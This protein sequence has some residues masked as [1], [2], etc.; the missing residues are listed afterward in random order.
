MNEAFGSAPRTSV[1]AAVPLQLSVVVPTFNERD[2]VTT[3]F[4]RLESALAGFSWEA[5]F[6]DDN[7]PDGTSEVVRLLASQD[8]RAR[9]IRRIGRRGLAGAC[10]E[11]I[12]A[13]SAPC[14]AVIDADLQHDETRLPQMLGLL[15][16][17][18]ADLVIGSRYVE[19]GSADSF[20]KQ[21]AGFSTLATEVAQRVLR[22]K[23]A[24]PMSGFFMIRRD[25]F[26]ELA[27]QLSTQGFKILLDVV[28]TAR[29][30]LRVREVPY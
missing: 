1:Q 7:S 24:D 10:I 22:V 28:A 4:Q 19:G 20:D 23:V 3:L 25:R 21:S 2:N 18:D 26:E 6:V 30:T 12:L 11:G 17:G 15:Q 16:G 5:I 14:V 8:G 13:S 29:G 27:P 9:C